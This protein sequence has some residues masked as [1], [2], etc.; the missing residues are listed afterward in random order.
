MGGLIWLASYPKSGNTWTRALLHNL[1]RQGGDTHSINEMTGLTSTDNAPVWYEEVLGKKITEASPAEIDSARPKVHKLIHDSSDGF[2]FLKTH[3]ALVA[4][5]GVPLVTAKW[6]AG[7][8]YIVRN[9]L[10]VAISYAHHMGSSID[11]SI[12]VMADK[13]R[14]TETHE[15][16]AYQIIGSWTENVESWTRK[17]NPSLLVMRYEDML[18][19]SMETF[20]RLCAWLN[21]DVAPERLAKAIELSSFDRLKSQEEEAGFKEKPQAAEKFFREG[22]A[23][24]WKATLNIAQIR[25]LIRDHKAQMAKYGYL[26]EAERF[27]IKPDRAASG[28]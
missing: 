17:P 7:A 13:G 4:H 20:G 18:N 25:R 22:K 12:E 16:G 23:G 28:G 9:P 19:K 8:I 6:T 26:D 14:W 10:D 2:V 5:A 1:I 15:K 24:Q 3:N 21:L 11:E 27:L